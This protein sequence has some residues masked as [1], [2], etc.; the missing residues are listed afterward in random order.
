MTKLK[1]YQYAK[2]GTCRKAVKWL[3]AKGHKLELIPILIHLH[4][5][6]N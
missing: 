1:V 5:K 6:T 3:E 2:C 4:Q